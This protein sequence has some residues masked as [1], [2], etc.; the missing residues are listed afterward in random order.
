MPT[1]FVEH[2]ERD[3]SEHEREQE[4]DLMFS[5]ERL[6][7]VRLDLFL[8]LGFLFFALVGI[9]KLGCD[10]PLMKQSE[11]ESDP[12]CFSG[13]EGRDSVGLQKKLFKN[14]KGD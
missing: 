7:T 8:F 3:D 1:L 5:A 13:E 12:S 10:L 2:E 14:T 4:R 6:A 9:L 11:R